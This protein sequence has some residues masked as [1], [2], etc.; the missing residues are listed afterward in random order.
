M[1]GAGGDMKLY[2]RI[3]MT[4]EQVKMFRNLKPFQENVHDAILRDILSPLQD[5]RVWR[6][7]LNTRKGNL[8]EKYTKH[9]TSL[10]NRFTK[11]KYCKDCWKALA[12]ELIASVKK[13][14]YRYRDVF[15]CFR[16]FHNVLKC[17]FSKFVHEKYNK[18]KS[19]DDE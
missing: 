11:S 19:A 13:E 14:K 10:W 18:E 8:V 2:G 3:E 12:C 15:G 4:D 6:I 7:V 16:E 17:I 1:Q 9:T 5:G